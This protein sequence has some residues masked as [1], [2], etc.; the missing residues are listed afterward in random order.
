MRLQRV[1]AALYSAGIGIATSLDVVSAQ[2]ERYSVN[3]RKGQRAL[4]ENNGDH[5]NALPSARNL[6]LNAI[7]HGPKK[8]KSD[9]GSS[10][11][12]KEKGDDKR[13][14]DDDDDEDSAGKGGAPPTHTPT[15]EDMSPTHTYEDMS[16]T[17]PTSKPHHPQPKEPK[18]S[19][20]P[21]YESSKD[22]GDKLE[23]S[24]K[25]SPTHKPAPPPSQ[26]GK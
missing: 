7:E 26:D 12:G 11:S 6:G 16:P 8:A 13:G 18:K 17:H 19:K 5:M 24:T 10:H 25:Q 20:K 1:L 3:H 4:K 22:K 23:K 9:K 14:D 21:K 2:K 15:R